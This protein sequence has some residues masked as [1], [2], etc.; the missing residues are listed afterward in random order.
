MK[1]PMIIGGIVLCV[2]GVSVIIFSLFGP[3]STKTNIVVEEEVEQ[4]QVADAAIQATVEWNKSKDNVVSLMVTGL[5][6]KYT[7]VAYELSY[8]S[9]G[10][11]QGVTSKPLDVTDK[12]TFTRDDIFLGTC[13]KNV[14]RPHVGVKQISVVL[15]FTDTAGVKSQLTKDVDL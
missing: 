3:K 8:E 5:A 15:E 14:C 2:L 4:I 7:Q 13:S 1:K 11:I 6:G 9:L 10:I 12:D